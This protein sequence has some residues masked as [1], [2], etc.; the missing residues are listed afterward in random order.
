MKA[1]NI[2]T[3]LFP[4]RS[5]HSVGLMIA[6]A[7]SLAVAA[8]IIRHKIM[9]SKIESFLFN[10]QY[11]SVNPRTNEIV[12]PKIK[13]KGDKIVLSNCIRKTTQQIADEKALWEQ[14]FYSEMRGKK[15]S[16]IRQVGHKI[17]MV[18]T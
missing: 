2:L 15:I 16:E 6:A 10:N 1:S 13:F 8:L 9:K 18:L 12:F 5:G 17:I 3:N 14:T 4:F 11:H 7:L